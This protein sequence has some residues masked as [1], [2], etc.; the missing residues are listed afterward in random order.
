[1]SKHI[2]TH[3]RFGV[4]CHDLNGFWYSDFYMVYNNPIHMKK[5]WDRWKDAEKMCE[6]KPEDN[7][8]MLID[9][10][11]PET[12]SLGDTIVIPSK[13]AD[14]IQKKIFGDE[15]NKLKFDVFNVKPITI[16]ELK[17]KIEV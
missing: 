12:D 14:E 15:Y 5:Q 11:N 8:E 10:Y 4:G 3:F 17:Q 2:F 13:Y 1:M 16:A 6:R 9:Q 7:R